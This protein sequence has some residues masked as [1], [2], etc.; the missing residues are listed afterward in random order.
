MN[1][2]RLRR[3]GALPIVAIVVMLVVVVAGTGTLLLRSADS[4][5]AGGSD[6]FTVAR[7]SFDVTIPAS[8][9]IAA[10]NQI[11]V[12]NQLEIRAVIT[13]IVDEGEIV[14][15]SDVLFKV[16]D[17]ELTNRVKDMQNSVDQAQNQYNTAVA[18][19]SIMLKERES[20]LAEADVAIE[21]ADLALKSWEEGDRVSRETELNLAIETAQKNYD[22]L[23]DRF[24]ASK[25]LLAQ[26]FIS[27]DEYRRDEI[28]LIE[29]GAKL[30]QA[31]LDMKVYMEYTIKQERKRLESDLKQARDERVR[32]KESYNAR[33]ASAESTMQSRLNQLESDKERL[34]DARRQLAS[35][36]VTAPSDG[37]VVYASSL[38][39]GGWRD[40][41]N[42]PQVGTELYRNQTVMVLPDTSEMVAE[43]KVNEA[44]SGLIRPGQRASIRSDARPD[45]V[46]SG[47]VV[48]IGVLAESGGWRDPNRRDYTVRI[49]IDGS[50]SYGLKPSM[51]CKANIYVENVSDAVYVP[52][53]SVFRTGPVAYVYQPDAGG[54][55]Q[56]KIDTG[57]ASE[58]YVE[59]VK[60]LEP[61]EQVL[62]RE[63]DAQRITAKVEV[64][65]NRRDDPRGG[66]PGEEQPH[67]TDRDSD[68]EQHIAAGEPT[69]EKQGEPGS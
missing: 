65:E 16:N 3:G 55:A 54:Y 53:Q 18:D 39:R 68:E 21:L 38:D 23:V 4:A 40:D 9:E 20:K 56:T 17:E 10:L 63:P 14:K 25:K 19:H 8:G 1:I 33:V 30:E 46:L 27:E 44:L 37:L 11:E 51:R 41:D 50:N 29:A 5:D 15:K 60:G 31:K 32:T 26:E 61:G 64:P 59:V 69:D 66:P 22:R 13:E 35:C 6:L 42:P 36:V 12:K 62:T 43:V 24:E 58:L 7:G 45:L 49:R 2:D 57:R 67:M 52:V 28:E 47:E 34:T 48:S